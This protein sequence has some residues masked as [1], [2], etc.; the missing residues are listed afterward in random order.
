MVTGVATP[1]AAFTRMIGPA[2]LPN[3]M[4][5]SA[6]QAPPVAAPGE[7]QIICGGPPAMSFFLSLPLEAY[8]ANRLSKDQNGGGVIAPPSEPS[9]ALISSESRERSHMRETFSGPGAGNA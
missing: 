8:T 4:T 6:F 2:L 7:S 1:P 3:T 9:R 5:P